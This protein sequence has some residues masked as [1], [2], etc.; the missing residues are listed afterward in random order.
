[1]AEQGKISAFQL[2][3]MLYPL[4]VATADLTVPA[5]TFKLAGRD[6][7]ISPLWDA[8]LGLFS[9]WMAV[10]LAS[11]YP[12]ETLIQYLV[13]ILGKWPGKALGLLFLFYYVHINGNIVKLSQELVTSN[14]LNYTPVIVVISGLIFVSGCAV[15][16]GL[17]VIARTA[18]MLVPFILL[19]TVL[20]FVL[21]TPDMDVHKL[22]PIMGLGVGPSLMGAIVPTAWF[23]HYIMISFL[24][25]YVKD[26]DKARKWG[27]IAVLVATCSLSLCNVY[28]LML[29]GNITGSF[30]Y[31]VIQ[32]ARYISIADFLEHL[33]ALVVVIWVAGVYLKIAIFYYVLALGM[34]HWLGLESYRPV[35]FPVGA[36]ILTFTLWSGPS[37][38][39]LVDFIGKATPFYSCTIHVLIPV[40]LILIATI[41][42]KAARGGPPRPDEQ[43]A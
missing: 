14:F 29:F 11:L 43:P 3:L 36:L 12:G 6:L 22:L 40:L 42:K 20:V 35:V 24:L 5:T 28:T 1:M 2:G 8:L 33:E 18:Q 41:R 4:V 32:A 25:P 7:W 19:L 30:T 34:A 16:G 9:V 15:R 38:Q 27:F 17:E 31:P 21:L 39:D 13:R 10:R 37:M 26:P 23:S